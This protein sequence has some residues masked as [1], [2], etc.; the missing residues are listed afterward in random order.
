MGKNDVFY[1]LGCGN[2]IGVSI[3]AEEFGVKKAVGID[4]DL[5]KIEE[6]RKNIQKKNFQNIEFLNEDIL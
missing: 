1:H 4:I 3:A 6:S 2:G 5:K